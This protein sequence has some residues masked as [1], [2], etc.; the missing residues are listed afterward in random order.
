MIIVHKAEDRGASTFDW[1]D[2]RDTFS[3]ADYY[4]PAHIGFRQLLVVNEIA[5]SLERDF[6]RIAIETWRSSPMS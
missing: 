1:L 5:F 4:D 2:S 3:F 6:R